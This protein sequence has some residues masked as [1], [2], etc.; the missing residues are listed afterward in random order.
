MENPNKLTGCKD[1]EI[2]LLNL[3]DDKS[4]LK[5]LQLN[6]HYSDI[7]TKVF[8]KKLEELSPADFVSS[9]VLRKPDFTKPRDISLIKFY[10]KVKKDIEELLYQSIEDNDVSLTEYMLDRN[11]SKLAF[12]KALYLACRCDNLDIVKYI[13]AYIKNKKE[14]YDIINSEEYGENALTCAS[15]YGHFDIINFLIENGANQMSKNF[16]LSGSVFSGDVEIMKYL[17]L[18][19]ADDIF[20]FLTSIFEENTL[21]PDDLQDLVIFLEDNIRKDWRDYLRQELLSLIEEFQPYYPP[22]VR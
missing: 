9:Q 16:A 20:D 13:L 1:T 21:D 15:I 7:G 22:S 6:K 18:N 4:L 2:M 8:E 3:L 10:F 5:I 17:I 12:E 19:G 11:H 14:R